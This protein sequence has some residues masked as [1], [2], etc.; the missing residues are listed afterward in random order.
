[1]T[2]SSHFT[3]PI[4]LPSMSELVMYN[5]RSSRLSMMGRLVFHK[6][7]GYNNKN[8]CENLQITNK[9]PLSIMKGIKKI[10]LL[11]NW[12]INWDL[13]ALFEH[14]YTKKSN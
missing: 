2:K 3:I 12:S 10:L 1:M 6:A 14:T 13:T 5:G 7:L 8:K 9:H 4:I 11:W